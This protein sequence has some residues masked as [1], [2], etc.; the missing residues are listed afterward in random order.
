MTN[1]REKSDP[2]IVARKPTN[3]TGRPVAE[4]VERRAG[5]EGNAS[6]QSRSRA[7]NRIDLSQALDRVRKAA[8]QR[9]KERFTSLLHHVTVERLETAFLALKRKAAAG[10]DGLTWR[11]YDVDREQNLAGHDPV[12]N[13]G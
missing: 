12:R 11:V 2:A 6:R 1:G 4:P 8:R 7:Q 3:K 10:V 13:A 9:K 5:T